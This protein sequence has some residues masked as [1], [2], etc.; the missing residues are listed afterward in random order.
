MALGLAA[1]H[2]YRTYNSDDASIQT[3]V[4]D[5]TGTAGDHLAHVGPDN[6]IIKTP[7]YWATDGWLYG[8]RTGMLVSSVAFCVAGLA[9]FLAAAFYLL[10]RTGK[11]VGWPA[12][13]AL[14][15]PALLGQMFIVMILGTNY[16]NAEIGVAFALLVA[17]VAL[18]SKRAQAWPF[19]RWVALFSVFV[20]GAGFFLFDDPYFSYVF[21]G[22]L[23]LLGLARAGLLRHERWSSLVLALA[24][25]AAIIACYLWREIMAQ[26]DF[27]AL[28]E[29]A[30]RAFVPVEELPSKLWFVLKGLGEIFGVTFGP[31]LSFRTLA[32]VV[33]LAPIILLIAAYRNKGVRE[34]F[35]S[36]WLHQFLVLQIICTIG[37]YFISDT[38]VDVSSLRYLVMVPFSLALLAALVVSVHTN[39]ARVRRLAAG[40]F[41][42][43]L[44]VNLIGS[45]QT[46][47]V[48][49]TQDSIATA[50]TL[51]AL[52]PEYRTANWYKNKVD[53]QIAD[54]IE[55]RGLT[56]GYGLFWQANI[57]TYFTQGKTHTLPIIC[58]T[59]ES[60]VR[61]EWLVDEAQF[62]RPAAKTYILVNTS[63]TIPYSDRVCL[64]VE[65]ITRQFGKPAELTT[66]APDVQ[67]AV[68]DR[69]IHMPAP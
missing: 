48:R 9:L 1:A 25:G 4:R 60:V 29:S 24:A 38:P 47:A 15:W 67:L 21:F 62:E 6:F 19:W 55:R 12:V 2:T 16:R 20:L 22:P 69:D 45:L 30:H 54:E 13:L 43:L 26:F 37:A 58:A 8:S 56:K 50:H 39:P 10:R 18:A 5:W 68:Y 28:S 42:L 32:A 35:K 36:S 33:S 52:K 63:Q 51:A 41:G 61:Q 40:A 64:S 14:L 23:V 27:I 46:L 34:S 17:A 66:I 3:I 53:I 65:N 11:A 57:T 49:G 7:F 31:V 44:A 59:E